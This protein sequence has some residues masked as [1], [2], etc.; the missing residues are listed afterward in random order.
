MILS[1]LSLLVT[2]LTYIITPSVTFHGRSLLDSSHLSCG[3]KMP[4]FCV[5]ALHCI[6]CPAL[7]LSFVHDTSLVTVTVISEQQVI[8]FAL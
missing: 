3:G 4:C 2:F 1:S 5:E 6:L 8:L 7:F